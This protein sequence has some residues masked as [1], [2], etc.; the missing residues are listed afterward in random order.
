[1]LGELKSIFGDIFCIINGIKH[2]NNLHISIA[3]GS[4]AKII[5]RYNFESKQWEKVK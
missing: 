5:K 1:M 3:V 2:G 4:P